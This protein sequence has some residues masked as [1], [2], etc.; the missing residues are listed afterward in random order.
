MHVPLQTA[1]FQAD[2]ETSEKIIMHKRLTTHGFYRGV[3]I[4]IPEAEASQT[5]AAIDNISIFIGNKLFYFSSSD[6]Q[7]WLKRGGDKENGHVVLPVPGLRYT[8]SLVI[9]N[10]TN[11]YGDFNLAI[12][13]IFDFLFHPARYA[14]T[15]FFILCM[16]YIY[17]NYVSSVYRS[18]RGKN[19]IQP[20]LF[21][22][23]ILTG[24]ALRINGFL[25]TSGWLDE[26]YSSVVSSPRLPF[27]QTFSDPG[28]PPLYYMLLRLA[29][30]LFGWSEPVG[31]MVSVVLGTLTIVS[32]YVMTLR[33]GSKKAAL[34]AAL[35]M[36]LSMYAVGFSQEMR[37][38]IMRMFLVPLCAA[39]FLDLQK[40]ASPENMVLYCLSCICL[41]NTHYFGVIFI[42]ANFIYYFCCFFVSKKRD[43]NNAALFVC[44]NVIAALSFLPFF[45]ITAL[46]GA[47]ADM[48]FNSSIKPPGIPVFIL[49]F[50]VI[51]FFYC[52]NTFMEKKNTA[53]SDRRESAPFYY[54]PVL[55]FRHGFPDFAGFFGVQAHIQAGLFSFNSLPARYRGVGAFCPGCVKNKICSRKIP[56]Q[57]LRVFVLRF[58][59]S[60]S[61][62]RR[63]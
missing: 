22:I 53:N 14:L 56:C 25:R 7:E 62:R 55:C 2:G 52:R 37:S 15:Y 29:F 3:S 35:F 32:V 61:T 39:F 47:L 13:G 6:I 26:L 36:A 59:L 34:L 45:I 38:N 20:A 44:A 63:R 33:S 58:V 19:W 21:V 18:L 30:T 8:P 31:K 43:R 12:M 57:I 50:V 27:L 5:L 23:I 41:A 1:E 24:F 48:E 10:W 11:Y 49:M 9:K 51:V 28:N 42:M 60:G 16:I 4:R 40:R 17:K 54:V 46:R